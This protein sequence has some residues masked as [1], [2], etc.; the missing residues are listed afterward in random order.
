MNFK[1]IDMI[2][3]FVLKAIIVKLSI[4]IGSSK[5]PLIPLECKNMKIIWK[6]HD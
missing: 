6:A 5:I 3:S 1:G 2:Q 4:K